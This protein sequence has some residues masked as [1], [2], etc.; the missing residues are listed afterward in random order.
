LFKIYLLIPRGCLSRAEKHYSDVRLKMQ[1]AT[2]R[3]TRKA[4]I[5]CPFEPL[6]GGE[7]DVKSL[8]TSAS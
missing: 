2:S 4:F 6:T 5:P 7:A 3:K 1:D 8:K